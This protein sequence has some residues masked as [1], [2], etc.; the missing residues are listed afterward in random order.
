MTHCH[1]QDKM[2][3]LI[4]YYYACHVWA[5][6]VI[7]FLFDKSGQ[8]RVK[9]VLI[10]SDVYS[11]RNENIYTQKINHAEIFLNKKES[12]EEWFWWWLDTF[13]LFMH[14]CDKCDVRSIVWKN[15]SDEIYL[16]TWKGDLFKFMGMIFFPN[17]WSAVKLF[18]DFFY[19]SITCCFVVRI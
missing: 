3:V 11:F 16:Q 14:A 6:I 19:N 18:E 8:R 12:D 7:F 2:C 17:T 5:H 4:Y 13:S 9:I 1:E 10:F 15:E